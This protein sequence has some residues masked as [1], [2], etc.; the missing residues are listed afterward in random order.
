M[1]LIEIEGCKIV[2]REND[3]GDVKQFSFNLDEPN[4]LEKDKINQAWKNRQLKEH[5]RYLTKKYNRPL[6]KAELRD[7]K[8]GV[9]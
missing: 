5:I 3:F 4:N 1:V 6:T 7:V 9:I 8:K 2:I